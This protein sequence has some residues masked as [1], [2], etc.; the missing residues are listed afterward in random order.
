M[1]FLVNLFHINVTKSINYLLYFAMSISLFVIFLK[2]YV[3]FTP[4]DEIELIKNGNQAVAF[5][6]GGALFGYAINLGF[7]MFYAYDVVQYL[8]FAVLSAIIQ[9][10]AHVAMTKVFRQLQKE[11]WDNENIAAGIL[12]GILAICVGILNGASAY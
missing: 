3:K 8:L 1:E 6:F 12:F 4:I 9:L 11:V 7:A 10:L 2:T 5:A